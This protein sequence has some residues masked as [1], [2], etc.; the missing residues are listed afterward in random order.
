MV[1][2]NRMSPPACVHAKPVTTPGTPVFIAVSCRI[3]LRSSI[4]L[5][6]RVPTVTTVFS[7]LTSLT[8]ALRHSVS[9]RFLSPRTPDSIV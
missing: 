1:S 7:P 9:M 8:A 6:C 2:K 4:S 3:G 5:S